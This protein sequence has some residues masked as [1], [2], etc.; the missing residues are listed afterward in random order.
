MLPAN[1][2]PL[3]GWINPIKDNERPMSG[4]KAC[5]N[6]YNLNKNIEK[7]IPKKIK[8]YLFTF[9]IV[10]SL[11]TNNFSFSSLHKKCKSILYPVHNNMQS[12]SSLSPFS[13]VTSLP[14][15]LY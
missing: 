2:P 9:K 12:N 6:S 8:T 15:I 11:S 4:W 7:I 13:N 3:V 5:L 14:F 1:K 10:S